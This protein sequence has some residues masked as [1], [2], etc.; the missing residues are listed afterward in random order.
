MFISAQPQVYRARRVAR[1]VRAVP[2]GD[3]A[4]VR[5]NRVIGT[6]ALDHHDPFLMFDEFLSAAPVTYVE[7]VPQHP[8]RGFETI[9]Y[10][11]EGGLHH[12]D[13]H[14]RAGEVEPGGAHWMTAGRGVIHSETPFARDG[15]V[16]G[17]QLWINLPSSA[18]LAEPRYHD[19]PAADIPAVIFPGAE[20]RLLAG[21]FHGLLGPVDSPVTQP[22]IA[23]VRLRHEGEVT[24][25]LPED[26]QGFIYVF[27]GGVAIEQTL[28]NP[29]Q[30]GLLDG[31][32][33]LNLV[34][35][36]GG[37][38]ALIATARPLNEPVV[39]QGPFVMNSQAEIKQAFS[40]YQ[41]GLF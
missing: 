27:S 29:G 32:N 40:D 26:H 11:L 14:G 31:G 19:I 38:R 28:V 34:A 7:D 17:V 18:K 15:R 36:Q 6:A 41:K 24:V 3:G 12:S 21:R 13:S 5:L 35:G 37:A 25:T 22:F 16:H 30:A 23:D 39:R 1:L 2:A 4:A 8:S 20:V 10:M 9:T 33:V